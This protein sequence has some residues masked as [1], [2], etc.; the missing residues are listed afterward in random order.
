MKEAPLKTSSTARRG[1]SQLFKWNFLFKFVKIL[2]R[3]FRQET[4]YLR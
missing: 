3:I 1:L 2:S 4:V